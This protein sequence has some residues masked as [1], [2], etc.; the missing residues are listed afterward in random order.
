MSYRLFLQGLL[1]LWLSWGSS[2]I[3]AG[4]PRFDIASLCPEASPCTRIELKGTWGFQKGILL[5]PADVLQNQYSGRLRIPDGWSASSLNPFA[6]SWQDALD[7][8]T[9]WIFLKD[10]PD[11]QHLAINID[12]VYGGYQLFWQ[13]LTPG[14]QAQLIAKEGWNDEQVMH[15]HPA[16]QERYFP[17]PTTER[18]DEYLLLLQVS[19]SHM[20]KGGLRATPSLGNMQ[21]LLQIDEKK[22]LIYGILLGAITIIAIYHGLLFLQRRDDKAA[23]WLAIECLVI[24]AHTAFMQQLIE[25]VWSEPSQFFARVRSIVL[26]VA[27]ILA[28]ITFFQF[29]RASFPKV[30]HPITKWL[31]IPCLVACGVSL[32]LPLP[33]LTRLHLPFFVPAMTILVLF[34]AWRSLSGMR[35]E[36][37]LQLL[38]LGILGIGVTSMY[39]LWQGT[40]TVHS[41]SLLPYA[42]VGFILLQ[43]AVI[44][45]RFAQAY[46]LAAR[47]SAHLQKEVERQTRNIR[48]IL[49]S[50]HQGVFTIGG[51]DLKLGSERSL[52]LSECL[53]VPPEAKDL[54]SAFLDRIS[55][56]ADQ[57]EQLIQAAQASLDE[58]RL[59]F[60]LNR[61]SFP[62][63][64]KWLEGLHL[65]VDW[66]PML[67]AEGRVEYL[68]VCLRDVTELKE[69]RQRSEQ[70]ES[71]LQ[72]IKEL[73]DIP[74]SRFSGFL[75]K[76]GE[77]LKE[78]TNLS[79]HLSLPQ[80]A[81][82]EAL[83]RIM[84]NLHTVKGSARTLHLRAIASAAHRAEQKVSET[85]K[86][87]HKHDA[88]Q[89]MAALESVT[90]VVS[91]YHRIGREKLG[92]DM[93]KNHARIPRQ[94]LLQNQMLLS[95]VLDDLPPLARPQALHVLEETQRYCSSDMPSLMQDM[96]QGL[97]SMARDLHR[98]PPYLHVA[99]SNIAFTEEGVYL[100]QATFIHI[101]RNALD[102]GLETAEERQLMGKDPVGTIHI[103]VMEKGRW[104]LIECQDDG[105]GLCLDEI[106]RKAQK[107]GLVPVDASLKPLEIA[108]LIF[109]SGLSTREAV[110]EVSG[111]GIGMDAVRS[112]VEK[113]GGRVHIHLPE[114]GST[115]A[116]PFVLQIL[117]PPHLWW[118]MHESS[119]DVQE[120]KQVS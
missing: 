117:L 75:H 40:Q 22:R 16:L 83:R 15:S 92:W 68:L 89:V 94:V 36:P 107:K 24:V 60:D 52:Y 71:E 48:S 104:A 1:I 56:D 50:M 105:R 74:E 54:R 110:T 84:M 115:G 58:D 49:D 55:L 63:E 96:A 76:T 81:R 28:P 114:Q 102:H 59:S 2:R 32:F 93:E 69:L 64:V 86:V 34:L 25:I 116:V 100:L 26:Y 66:N 42:Q 103:T 27:H 57:K 90:M 35:G 65:E 101:L 51:Q 80:S 11:W 77:Y 98:N 118:R 18:A 13:A 99:G 38:I 97:D 9:Y 87:A 109:T 53:Q 23:L 106:L 78:S 45:H 112:F 14:S 108:E 82:G 85:Q 41:T 21:S 6:S 17:L 70:H 37:M 7:V 4:E 95:R 20:A 73:I 47:L 46:S 29:L 39:D 79:Q 31:F 3:F 61:G 119:S 8:G 30:N 120:A 33:I 111:R 62:L 72:I 113:A 5:S 43:G 12:S 10:L 44:S 88:H 91:T 19:N 67:N